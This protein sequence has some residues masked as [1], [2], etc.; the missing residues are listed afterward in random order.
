MVAIDARTRDM[1]GEGWEVFIHGRTATGLD[2]IAWA[3]RVVAL[4]AGEILL[5]SMDRD[6]RRSG[7]DLGLTRA[8]VD[9][10]P[11]PVIASGG[12]GN[13]EHLREGLVDGGASAVLAASIFHD[14]VHTIDEAKHIPRRRRGS[15]KTNARGGRGMNSTLE[16]SVTLDDVYVVVGA[17]RVPLAAELAGYLTLEIAEGSAQASGEVDPRSVY[18]GEEGTV[19]LVVRP[20]REPAAGDTEASIRSILG[21][22]LDASGSQT[23]ALGSVARRKTS[24]GMHALVEELGGR[25]HSRQPGRREARARAAR[26]RGEAGDPGSRAKRIPCSG[27]ARAG[28]ASALSLPL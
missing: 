1:A 27:G 16:S 5:T 6:G 22:L 13:L 26:A 8:V 15:G 4:G 3:C 28:G 24:A 10:V 21:R 9:A 12:V 25:A 19:A 7:Y 17:K 14:G 2:A 23:P 20:R 11:I 18:I